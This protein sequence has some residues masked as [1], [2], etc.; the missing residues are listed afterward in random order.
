ML[1]SPD[2]YGYFT[3]QYIPI[4]DF[5]TNIT[6]VY[7]GRML[8]ANQTNLELR[9]TPT[10]FELGVKF[11]YDI[12]INKNLK[13]QLNTGVQN[14]FNSYQSDFETGADRDAGYIYGPSQP[15]T[16]YAGLKVGIF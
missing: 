8:V 10:F 6:G 5:S 2:A 3:L 12:H 1:K 7:T 9:D 14:L 15:R 11:S 16:F 13:L 4:E